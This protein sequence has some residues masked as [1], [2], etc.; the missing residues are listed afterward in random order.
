MSS[1]SSRLGATPKAAGVKSELIRVIL[2]DDE[3]LMREH[4]RRHLRNHPDL[5][6]VGEA[7]SV[8]S[9]WELISEAYPEVVFLDVQMP[10]EEGFALLPM[11]ENLETPPS[12][13][14]VTAFDNFA[15]RAFEANAL[16]Y[17]TKPV[18]PERLVRTVEKVRRERM[19]RRVIGE[20]PLIPTGRDGI[21]SSP[22]AT[23]PAADLPYPTTDDRKLGSEDLVMLSEKP[24]IRMIR[25]REIRA[26]EAQGNYTLFYLEGDKNILMNRTLHHWEEK[27]P[28]E[29]FL[30]ANRSLLVNSELITQIVKITREEYQVFFKDLSK[31]IS[32][33]RLT[34]ERIKERVQKL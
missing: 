29:L 20:N 21:P 33:S 18:I 1:H 4:L 16:D 23:T 24:A 6:I 10:P 28:G 25:T 9:A 5:E 15:I 34:M 14:F 8:A 13:V 17:L 32:V 11:L 30:K 26:V 31:P 22:S 19:L 12:V 3:R 7:D 2:V 27:L